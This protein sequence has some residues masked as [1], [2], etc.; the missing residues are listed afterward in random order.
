MRLFLICLLA[1]SCDVDSALHTAGFPTCRSFVMHDLASMAPPDLDA[2]VEKCTGDRSAATCFVSFL[3]RGARFTG[4]VTW[5]CRRQ[6][7]TGRSKMLTPGE[8][9]VLE[10]ISELKAQARAP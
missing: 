6:H 3:Q 5:D 10:R 1:V 9:Y 8:A 7:I 2:N 4:S